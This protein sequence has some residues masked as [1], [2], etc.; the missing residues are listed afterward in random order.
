M[1]KPVQDASLSILID[2]FA[3][4]ASSATKV[5]KNRQGY[6]RASLRNLR[7]LRAAKTILVERYGVLCHTSARGT[8]GSLIVTFSACSA[9]H[10]APF[11]TNR[12]LADCTS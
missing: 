6:A 5:D 8:S 10:D 4:I 9:L 11:S 3:R 1:V 12:E 7:H 2:S